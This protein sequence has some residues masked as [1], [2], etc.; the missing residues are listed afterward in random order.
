[1][2]IQLAVQ[3]V[4]ALVDCV[5]SA[6]VVG[7]WW[8][9]KLGVCKRADKVKVRQCAGSHLSR[10][11]FTMNRSFKVFDLVATPTLPTVSCEFSLDAEVFEIRN[12]DSML[13]L[14]SLA[15][16]ATLVDSQERRMRKAIPDLVISSSMRW[17][18]SV[19]VLDLYL[20]PLMDGDIVL[21][22]DTLEG[23]AR[24]VIWFSSPEAARLL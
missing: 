2:T 11:N 13:G 21:L 15:E 5:A 8:P 17:I 24:Y 1:M 6:P 10:V 9:K 18:A 22:I 4:A 19:S 7:K 3:E 12:D 14:H 20:E 16:N 23:Y